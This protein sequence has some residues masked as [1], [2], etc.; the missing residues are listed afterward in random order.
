MIGAMGIGTAILTAA[1]VL[2]VGLLFAATLTE[3][4]GGKKRATEALY[5]VSRVG[6]KHGFE[7]REKPLSLL[8]P[9]GG[10]PAV[11]H[12]HLLAPGEER[13]SITLKGTRPATSRL[14]NLIIDNDPSRVFAAGLKR[15][16]L[17]A[18]QFDR[19]FRIFTEADHQVVV[20]NL[21]EETGGELL[22]LVRDL[23][24]RTRGGHFELADL[25]GRVKIQFDDR[26]IRFPS[27]VERLTL[28]LVRLFRL[29]RAL[30][31]AAD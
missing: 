9:Q 25:A 20:R 24:C 23:A 21:L 19:A 2:L 15:L 13:D 28:D 12:Y 7:V 26:G 30:A 6:S 17:Q 8:L 27:D 14:G 22:F 29:Y 1:I 11:V 16:V 3:L 31:G 10:E 5:L 18:P 4:R